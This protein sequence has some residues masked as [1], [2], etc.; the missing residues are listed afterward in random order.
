[1]ETGSR[2][3]WGGMEQGWPLGTKLQDKNSSCC[4]SKVTID[5]NK[6]QCTLKSYKGRFSMFSP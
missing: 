3:Q 1:M 5:N 6:V 4:H 2:R